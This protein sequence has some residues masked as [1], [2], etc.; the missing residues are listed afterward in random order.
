M[1]PNPDVGRRGC[2]D[3]RGEA[4]LSGEETGRAKNKSSKDMAVFEN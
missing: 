1:P 2:V 4:R 3:G